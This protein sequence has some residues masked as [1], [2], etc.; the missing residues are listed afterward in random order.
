MPSAR[1]AA[2]TA[3]EL[4]PDLAEAHV[5]LADVLLHFDRDW[6][7]AD[8]E[9]RRAIQCNPEYALGYHWYSNLLS[10]R[11]QHDAAHLAIATALEIDPVSIITQ[12]WAGVTSYLARQF[13]D[14]IAHYKE[15][16]ELDPDYVWAHMY[17]AQALEQKG[18]LRTAL[19]EFET[20]LALANG[21]NGVKAMQAHTHAVAGDKIYAREIL[22]ELKSKP[23]ADQ[24][25]SYDIAATYAALGEPDRMVSWLQRAC[26]ERSMKLFTLPRDPRF[27]AFRRR[28]EFKEIVQ[29]I[30][31]APA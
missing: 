8:R 12:V 5:S 16:L 7:G 26:R 30:G 28:S 27:D 31:L 20:A 18:E 10:A 23:T 2:L 1:R 15:A 21:N 29:Q 3:I 17:L 25:P 22:R 14:A 4:N 19:Q 11:G 9:Y 24:L 13:D 6:L